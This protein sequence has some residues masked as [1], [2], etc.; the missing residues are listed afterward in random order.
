MGGHKGLFGPELPAAAASC[1]GAVLTTQPRVLGSFSLRGE[2][3]MLPPWLCSSP[4]HMCA[5]PA[6]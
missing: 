3:C 4:A 6:H 1:S 5:L 2:P